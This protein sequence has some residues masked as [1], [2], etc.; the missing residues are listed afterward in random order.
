MFIWPEGKCWSSTPPLLLLLTEAV[1]RDGWMKVDGVVPETLRC[2]VA[3]PTAAFKRFAHPD[4]GPVSV[5]GMILDAVHILLRD[6]KFTLNI[7]H[8]GL[9]SGTVTTAV[10]E[11][12][13]FK[14]SDSAFLFFARFKAPENKCLLTLFKVLIV[15]KV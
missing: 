10:D 5:L 8:D 1:S 9:H 13:K 4:L 3:L 6:K 14:C 7:I 11:K 2:L 12:N 15:D